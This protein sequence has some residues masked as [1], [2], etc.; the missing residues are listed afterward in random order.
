MS[1]EAIVKVLQSPEQGAAT[2]VIAAIGKEWE[3]KGG[4][5]LEMCE[6]SQRGEDD[7]NVFGVGYVSQTYD[8]KSEARL[9]KD[10]L[11]IV[12]ISDDR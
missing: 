12:G 7:G 8:S 6:E 4:K 2:T 3:N 5:Y 1:N 10:S 9:W 11:K